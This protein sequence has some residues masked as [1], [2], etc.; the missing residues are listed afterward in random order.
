MN[1]ARNKR[2]KYVKEGAWY[3][4]SYMSLLTLPLLFGLF[5]G[6]HHIK[7]SFH[8]PPIALAQ[9]VTYVSPLP[10]GK[11]VVTPTPTIEVTTVPSSVPVIETSSSSDSDS[12]A[13][14]A[15][16]KEV[17]GKDYDKAMSL[18]TNPVCHENGNLNPEAVNKNLNPDGTLS[19]TD[20]G[21]FQI[22]D[23]WQG[24]NHISV[25]F[26]KNYRINTDIAKEIYDEN[27]HTFIRWTCGRAQ[28]I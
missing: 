13:I 19:S 10:T 16:I 7:L 3:N 12:L 11:I 24:F 26:L 27:G 2:N 25:R 18:L 8:F 4:S 5:Y 15:Y 14:K 1:T 17:F 20:Y 9:E 28:G 21:L 23:M 6:I 22:N